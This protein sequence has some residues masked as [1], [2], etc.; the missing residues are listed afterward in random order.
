MRK[1]VVAVL[2]ALSLLASVG[3][4]SAHNAGHVNTPNGKCVNV[5]AGNSVAVPDENPHQNVNGE[6]D[7]DPTQPGDQ[8]G[9]RHGADQGNSRVEPRHCS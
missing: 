4:A 3:V 7:L 9:A 8:I 5:G 1:I 6:L 2:L